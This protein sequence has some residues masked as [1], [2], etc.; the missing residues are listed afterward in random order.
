M[1]GKLLTMYMRIHI[2][3]S[4]GIAV[5]IVLDTI[6]LI[7][8]VV[9]VSIYLFYTSPSS[10]YDDICIPYSVVDGATE[11]TGLIAEKTLEEIK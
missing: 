6:S 10:L 3:V 11:G 4:D 1:M 9:V 2:P 8:F 7:V 5:A